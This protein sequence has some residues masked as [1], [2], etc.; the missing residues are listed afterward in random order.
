MF[1]CLLKALIHLTS[2][3]KF[4]SVLSSY[5]KLILPIAVAQHLLKKKEF[6]CMSERDL[7]MGILLITGKE[8]VKALLQV[9]FGALTSRPLSVFSTAVIKHS[10]ST[11]VL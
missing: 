5:K 6:C 3:C 8:W 1:R 2:C 10:P 11:F 9:E 4:F 7:F